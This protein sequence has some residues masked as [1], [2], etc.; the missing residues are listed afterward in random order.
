MPTVCSATELSQSGLFQKMIPALNS[1]VCDGLQAGRVCVGLKAGL[2]RART[3]KHDATVPVG[4]NA[5][6]DR[7]RTGSLLPHRLIGAGDRNRTGVGG[8]QARCP[9]QH[10][11]H[12]PVCGSDSEFQS[13]L[14]I[15]TPQA[16]GVNRK[17]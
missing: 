6:G 14:D 9:S 12:R 13:H 7:V 1:L 17:C 3:F 8:I 15:V 5:R 16:G 10:E 11:R 4:V 2:V